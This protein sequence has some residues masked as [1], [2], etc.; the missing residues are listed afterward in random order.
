MFDVGAVKMG[1]VEQELNHLAVARAHAAT[2]CLDVSPRQ[3]LD[4]SPVA[5]ER[6]GAPL[7]DRS[8]FRLARQ[9][10]V[11]QRVNHDGENAP[12]SLTLRGPLCR[13]RQFQRTRRKCQLFPI[14][15][16]NP[17]EALTNQLGAPPPPK[18]S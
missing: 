4:P 16:G 6:E 18:A 17:R 8:Y 11:C 5:A 7:D 14:P 3:R 9:N 12:T 10:G 13:L 15:W 1:V 2:S